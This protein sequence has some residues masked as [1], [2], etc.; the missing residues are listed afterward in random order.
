MAHSSFKIYE[1]EIK[2]DLRLIDSYIET[3]YNQNQITLEEIDIAYNANNEQIENNEV[4]LSFLEDKSYLQN[5]FKKHL[6]NSYF[7]ILESFFERSIIKICQIYCNSNPSIPDISTYERFGQ[8]ER[9]TFIK[10]TIKIKIDDLNS[11]WD[12][13]LKYKR[14]RDLLIHCDSNL[15]NY[16]KE[17]EKKC[18]IELLKGKEEFV[19][20]DNLTNEVSFVD[21]T[22]VNEYKACIEK[23]LTT[24]T[25]RIHCKK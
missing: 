10:K 9:K 12:R 14:L 15:N 1:S 22:M 19:K 20:I 17:K 2:I 21:L 23:Y 8:K 5:L 4:L 25:D 3:S 7:S 11:C 16:K 6:F 24:I 13:I 18:L